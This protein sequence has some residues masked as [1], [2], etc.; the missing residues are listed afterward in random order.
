MQMD[1]NP[2]Q[3]Q[4]KQQEKKLTSLLDLWA[5]KDS[6]SAGRTLAAKTKTGVRERQ[7]AAG[8][9]EDMNAGKIFSEKKKQAAQK[10]M[11]GV[12]ND[13]PQRKN[14]SDPKQANRAGTH[15]VW[16]ESGARAGSWGTASTGEQESISRPTE[17]GSSAEKRITMRLATKPED[18][19]KN[20][21]SPR[22]TTNVKGK[23]R[24]T[25]KMV[26]MIFSFKFK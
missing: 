10:L 6:F 26:K 4:I 18:R 21:K 1:Q 16:E 13:E 2:K 17:D 5:E 15:S 14:E 19:T 11:L 20:A 22:S 12:V 24:R 23:V 25:T 9:R 3:D 7:V 8:N